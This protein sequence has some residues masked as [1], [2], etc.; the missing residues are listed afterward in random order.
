ML[1]MTKA[2]GWVDNSAFF[3]RGR[4]YAQEGRVELLGMMRGPN[5][6]V[7]C[8]AE[9]H[10]S[11]LYDVSVDFDEDE[12]LDCG[13]DCP[14]YART[15]EM[16]KHVAAVL[17]ALCDRQKPERA[18]SAMARRMEDMMR[19]Q[20]RVWLDGLFEDAQQ[21][22]VNAVR[23]RH[24]SRGDVRLF[25]ILHAQGQRMGLELRIGRGRMYAVRSMAG[26]AQA[27]GSG[28][29]ETYGKELTFSHT[30][31]E[32]DP[33]D[34]ALYRQV[35][36]LAQ[37]RG[38]IRGA[39]LL[40]VEQGLDGV[41]RLLLG[42]EAELR[43]EGKEPRRVQIVEGAGEVEGRLERAGGDFRL[44]LAAPRMCAGLRGAYTLCPEEGEIRCA[45]GSRF[46]AVAPL[47]SIA[48][49]W[50]GGLRMDEA[51][52][53]KVCA[54]L[55]LP[56]GDA[57]HMNAGRELLLSMAPMP[58]H[59]RFYVDMDGR[60]RLTC[61]V[62]YDYGAAVL[63]G[64]E[65]APPIR[66]DALGEMQAAAAAQRLF[67]E[68]AGP[69][70]WAFS[71]DEEAVFTLLSERLPEL[72]LDGEVMVAERLTQMNV[73]R[74]RTMTFGVSRSGTQLL[75]QGD[76]GGL[77]Q[78]ELEAAYG[79][80]RQKRRYVRLTDGTFLSG[81][82]LEQAA[83][84]GEVLRGLDLSAEELARGANVPLG[85]AM[86]LEAALADREEMKLCEPGELRDFVA[87]L[88]RARETD[89]E[90]PQGLRAG[91]R[92]YQRTGYGWLCAM[93]K[94]GLGG[95]LAD[96]M[97][98]GKTVQALAM[99]LSAQE[100]GEAVRA[101]VVC[102]ASL[103][104]N[105][106]V[107]AARFAPSLRCEVLAGTAAKRRAQIARED[108]PELLITSYDQLRRDAQA[109]H[110]VV[111]THVLLDEAQSIKNAASQGARAAKTL[112]ARS[113]FALTGTPIENRLSELWSIFDFLMPG[114]LPPYKRFRERFEAPIV[115]EGDAQ[116]QENLRRL[117]APFILRRMKADVLSDLPEKVETAVGS[118]LTAEQRRLYA[119]HA[120]KLAGELD[121]PG[122]GPQRRMQ[123]LAGLTRLRQLCCDPRL[124]LEG[125]AGGSGKLEQCAALC[126][127]AVQA[128][129]RVLLFSQFTS[130][131]DLLKARL[132]AE[133]LSLFLLTGD[134]DK[135]ERMRLVER[136]NAG[137]ADVF[138]IS[139]KA[140]GTGLNLTGADVVIHYDPWWNTAAQNQA[141]D[142]AY[143]IGQTRG[144]QVLRL[145]ASGTIEERIAKMQEEKAALSD[146]I[147]A[148]DTP[149]APLDER[150]L[151][152]LLG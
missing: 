24:E 135:A 151:R 120:A 94:A 84:A 89:A 147:L 105:W 90:P 72:S 91:L 35:L 31:E 87:R 11:S 119:A 148:G 58:M 86:Y 65:E 103:Q 62:T 70:C 134:T 19:T 126:A 144:V 52:T 1:T 117:V 133:G 73:T 46:D 12:L 71:G 146:G 14:A 23:L 38:L 68:E 27:A 53:A 98:L 109:Y 32:L 45:F 17:I 82:A 5:G 113:R 141:T 116:A 4:A 55:L 100:R 49:E 66:R 118:E 29:R 92:P 9:V 136:F 83:Q 78:P 80:Y 25:P 6:F 79:A 99:L 8:E 149:A 124:C 26:F 40:L 125:Y 44:I 96:D 56:A 111:F 74:P 36:M 51:Y 114:Y 131:L 16:C 22:Q 47:L 81:E 121:A 77:T 140:G 106:Q 48:Q 112:V 2:R 123:I 50:P 10:G 85:R 130:M 104:L 34:R 129:H 43:M 110:G 139:L 127:Q 33:R 13:C 7:H 21:R 76:F 54:R 59:P 101:L 93:E 97:G 20:G 145:I 102:P 30:E 64:G 138:L 150:T 41:M 37:N 57:L 42:R 132:E 69:D 143:R 115:Q 15:G 88:S 95:I 142:R 108:A 39:Q 122:D 61:R 63:S 128:G 107:E 60:D 152:A 75:V 18:H 67:P 137:G 28:A 3:A